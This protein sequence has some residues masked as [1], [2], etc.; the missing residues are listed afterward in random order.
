MLLFRGF[1]PLDSVLALARAADD[2]APSTSMSLGSGRNLYFDDEGAPLPLPL[3]LLPLLLLPWLEEGRL[4]S[5]P[6]AN[7]DAYCASCFCWCAVS[8]SV[9][10]APVVDGCLRLRDS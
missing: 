7:F 3:L 4:G 6:N 1:F 9:S 10:A 5:S 8:A 2:S